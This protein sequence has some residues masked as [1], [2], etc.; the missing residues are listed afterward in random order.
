[1]AGFPRCT[2]DWEAGFES[3]WNSSIS[4][5]ILD[6]WVKCFDARG[7]RSFNITASDNK[8]GNREEILRR[9]FA[10]KKSDYRK[11]SKR[12]VLMKTPGGREKIAADK[13]YS[14]KLV[15]RRRTKNSVSNLF[16]TVFHMMV[17]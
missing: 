12:E 17:S 8:P 16:R 6:Q 5:I 7:A 3:P 13:A 2:F 15:S 10:N 4:T 1:M 14:K 11:Q 9:W